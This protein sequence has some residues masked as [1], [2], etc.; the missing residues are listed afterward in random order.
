MK[1]A[2]R[3]CT[4]MAQKSY[5]GKCFLLFGCSRVGTW[6]KPAP[7]D[8]DVPKGRVAM[9]VSILPNAAPTFLHGDN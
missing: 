1:G 2:K 5:A 8:S 9:P 3:A 4:S 6:M 7:V